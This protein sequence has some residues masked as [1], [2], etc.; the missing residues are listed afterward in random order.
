MEPDGAADGLAGNIPRFYAYRFFIYAYLWM[1][2]WMVYLQQGRGFSLTES[3]LVTSFGWVLPAGL[4]IP[5]GAVAAVL[6]YRPT[7]ALGAAVRPVLD[8]QLQREVPDAMRATVSSVQG[9]LA[10]LAVALLTVVAGLVSDRAGLRAM[11]AGFGILVLVSG[12][13]FLRALGP[14][15]RGVAVDQPAA[16][17]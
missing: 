4:E 10:H 5:T 17:S 6:G 15:A 1:P 3:S 16:R 9:L 13:G 2:V 8:H 11:F 12:A 7:L 14:G